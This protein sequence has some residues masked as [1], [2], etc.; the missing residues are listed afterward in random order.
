MYRDGLAGVFAFGGVLAA[1]S[2]G[3]SATE[4]IVF[5]IALNL[6]AGVSTIIA[7]RL[8]DRFG[9]RAVIITALR[10]LIVSALF[11]FFFREEGKTMFWI[12]GIILSAAVGPAQASSRSLLARVTPT[13]MQGEIF[14]LYATTGRVMSF[15]SPLLWSVLIAAFGATHCGILGIVIVLLVGLLLLLL[16]EAAAR[17]HRGRARRH[18]RQ[19]RRHPRLSRRHRRTRHLRVMSIR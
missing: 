5:G 2:F 18:L 11:V 1:V 17:R 12:G 7:G 13:G 16:G 19:P 9:A 6:V 8:D 3:F 4:V 14:G 10:I 15:L